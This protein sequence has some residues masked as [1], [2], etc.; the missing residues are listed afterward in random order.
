M[1]RIKPISVS[2]PADSDIFRDFSVN[3]RHLDNEELDSADLKT[4]D[5]RTLLFDIFLRQDSDKIMAIGPPVNNL[6]EHIL[7]ITATVDGVIAKT[8]IRTLRDRKLITLS[9]E[10]PRKSS[11]H[12]LKLRFGNHLTVEQEILRD[13]ELTPHKITLTTL[14]KNNRARWISDWCK[15][16]QAEHG[17]DQ[18]IFYDNHSSDKE[19]VLTALPPDSIFIDWDFPFGPTA[20]HANKYCQY[21]SL[22]HMRLRFGGK[23]PVLNFDIDELLVIKSNYVRHLMKWYK[24][25]LFDSYKVPF[26]PPE[27]DD[28]SFGDFSLRDLMPIG[29]AF[30]YSYLPCKIDSLLPHRTYG[31]ILGRYLRRMIAP[32]IPLKDAYFLHYSG[33]TTNWKTHKD[34]LKSAA[35]RKNMVEDRYVSDFFSA[36]SVTED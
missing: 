11:K 16:Y 22:N 1:R 27:H 7:P 20:S 18:V 10:C 31:T 23:T 12:Q 14:Q 33:I 3:K 32:V 4:F 5:S 8:R 2:L 35:N 34:R 6:A 25:I 29:S 36:A 26:I 30:K 21:G 17:V 13:P 19:A 9:I 24:S 15:Y 28:Y